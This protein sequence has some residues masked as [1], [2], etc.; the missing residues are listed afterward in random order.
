MNRTKAIAIMSAGLLSFS[1]SACG[2]PELTESEVLD[3]TKHVKW[4]SESLM[5]QWDDARMVINPLAAVPE[6]AQ[7]LPET[8]TLEKGSGNTPFD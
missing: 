7:D 1:L 2:G 5:P 3:P 6:A 8:L 4:A